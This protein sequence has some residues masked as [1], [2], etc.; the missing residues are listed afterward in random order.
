M[1]RSSILIPF[2]AR[3][4]VCHDLAG[5]QDSEWALEALSTPSARDILLHVFGDAWELPITS[6]FSHLL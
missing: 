1:P 6:W 2:L 4:I 5:W 3:C